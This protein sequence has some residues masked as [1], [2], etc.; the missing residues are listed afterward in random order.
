[1]LYNSKKKFV[2]SSLIPRKSLYTVPP[3]KPGCADTDVIWMSGHEEFPYFVSK[4]ALPSTPMGAANG[5]NS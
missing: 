1:M 5:P 2:T 4:N 3:S